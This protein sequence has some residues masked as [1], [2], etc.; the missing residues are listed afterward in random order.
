MLLQKYELTLITLAALSEEEVQKSLAQYEEILSA[1]GG[2]IITKE[3]WGVKKLHFPIKKNFQGH[4]V[5]YE[6]LTH[7]TQLDKIKKQFIFDENIL[8]YLLVKLTNKA[9]RFAKKEQ[10]QKVI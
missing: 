6:L 7:Y 10:I 3:D 2:E 8:R 9:I 4:Y 5:F 1:E